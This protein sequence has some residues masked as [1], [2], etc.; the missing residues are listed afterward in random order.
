MP[1]MNQEVEISIPS[2]PVNHYANYGIG[3]ATNSGRATATV[4][5]SAIDRACALTRACFPARYLGDEIAQT[6]A[7]APASAPAPVPVPAPAPAPAPAQAQAPALAPAPAPALG[8]ARVPALA[9]GPL[10]EAIDR[11]ANRIGN[12]GALEEAQIALNQAQTRAAE[13]Q[14]DKFRQYARLAE[15]KTRRE[16]EMMRQDAEFHAK[17]MKIVDNYS[18]VLKVNSIEFKNFFSWVF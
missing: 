11:V 2:P 17:R 9:V 15:I 1:F 5:S 10:Q 4:S 8:R 12:N 14:E 7:P 16:E 6:Q 3:I 18:D 13:A